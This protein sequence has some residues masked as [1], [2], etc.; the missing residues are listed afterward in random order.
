M[1]SRFYGKDVVR[2][3]CQ[4]CRRFDYA[5][6]TID[7]AL[8][9]A[10]AC[11]LYRDGAQAAAATQV[12][13]SYIKSNG[14]SF[15]LSAD[16][17]PKLKGQ[18]L[19]AYREASIIEPQE[20]KQEEPPRL[21]LRLKKDQASQTAHAELTDQGTQATV[22]MADNQLQTEPPRLKLKVL[23]EKEVQAEPQLLLL[24][25]LEEI[26]D[27]DIVDSVQMVD[28]EQQTDPAEPC[29][30]MCYTLY[31]VLEDKAHR[32][33]ELVRITRDGSWDLQ[34]QLN[35]YKLY[36]KMSYAGIKTVEREQQE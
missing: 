6:K 1:L 29:H 23:A 33:Q 11:I 34:R 7:E 12:E 31:K 21:V 10:E 27:S 26:N 19:Q 17:R 25:A 30:K 9:H 24:N 5:G 15:D 3:T 14:E 2:F 20:Q 18:I 32:L 4:R 16:Q 8:S 28:Q 35:S 13:P 22:K 36:S